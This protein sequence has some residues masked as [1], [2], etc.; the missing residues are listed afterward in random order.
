MNQQRDKYVVDM[1]SGS[2]SNDERRNKRQC[3]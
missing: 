3:F 2:A 1:T